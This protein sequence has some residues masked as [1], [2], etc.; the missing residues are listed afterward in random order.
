M[1]WIRNISLFLVLSGLLL[2]LIA[3]TKYYKFAQWVTG[4]I[5]LLQFIQPFTN[6]E[7]LWSKF[8]ISFQSFDYAMG[9]DKVVEEL[10]KMEEQTENT[11]LLHY[12]AS[13]SE[14]IAQI[15]QKSELQLEQTELEIKQTGEIEWMK[16][17]ASYQDKE[18]ADKEIQIPEVV[19][20]KLEETI[21]NEMISP[22]EL[23]IRDSLAEFYQIDKNKIE[24]VIQEAE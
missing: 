13:I 16:I 11:V 6:I 12:K 17:R 7:E 18:E 2:E 14:Q 1:E 5:L 3:D 4:V 9:T 24:V 19:P 22:I 20:I 15:L 10:Y 8:T 21:E 23:Y